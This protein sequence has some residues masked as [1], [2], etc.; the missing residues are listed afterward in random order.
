MIEIGISS[1]G[2]TTE[3]ANNSKIIS[4][5]ERIRNLVEEIE[6]A[7]RVGL[8]IFAIGEHHR[9]DFA[10]S[11]PEIVLT[12][13]AV[14]TKRIRLSSATTNISTHDPI[15]V[16]QNF[17]TLDALS[18]GRAEVMVGRSSFIEGFEL[19]GYNLNNY[20]QLFDEKLKLL[21]KIRDNEIL[22]WKGK[23]TH[24]VS[25]MGVYPRT[26]NKKLPVWV[27]TGGNLESSVK[28][29]RLG[30][31]I[32]YAIIGGNPLAFKTRVEAYKEI[33]YAE[34]YTDDDLRVAMHSW[35]YIAENEEEAVSEYFHP[36]KMMVDAISKD[37]A[38]W[39]SLTMDQ[40]LHE[41]K[42]GAMFVGNP[43]TVANKIINVM[44]ALRVD[45]FMLHLP[46]GSMPHEKVLNAISLLGEK[47]AP[48]VREYFANKKK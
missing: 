14:N 38:H 10:V 44:E 21:L 5:A 28:I 3:L 31:P 34:G 19:F 30:L 46:I 32:A 11:V 15:R 36:T 35:G 2:E 18:R 37:R 16:Y 40:Y 48:R 22:D 29:A 27:A 39:R 12:A 25:G 13:G 26:E 47:V 1:F 17:S 4:H 7:D 43:E 20:T 45:R 9:S 24:D 23:Y 8:D 6:L 42:A 33:G 41:I